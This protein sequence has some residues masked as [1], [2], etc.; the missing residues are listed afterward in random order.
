[1]HRHNYKLILL[2]LII[3]ISTALANEGLTISFLDVGQGDSELLQFN[4]KSM[5]IDGSTQD[6]GSRVECYLKERGVSSLDL[7]VATHPHEDH[8]GGLLTVLNDFPVRQILDSGEVHTSPTFESYL[9]L[10]DR[11]NIS[12]EVA[13]R[14][15]TINLDPDLE[16]E[17]LS[18]SATHFPDDLN[19]NSVVLKVNYENVSFLF[20]GDAGTEAENS[21]LSSGYDL[22]ADVL[23]VGHHGSSSASSTA[24]LNA[25]TPFASVI[26]VG[27]GNDYGHPTQRTLNALKRTGS[28]IYRTDLDGNIVVT[29][30]G[31]S[32][33]VTTGR[34]SCSSTAP[35]STSSAIA[36]TSTQP[37][38]ATAAVQVTSSSVPFVGSSKGK[39]YHYL[40]CSGA[41]SIKSGNLVT[42]ASSADARAAGYTPC[43]M[44]NPP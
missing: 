22:D 32:I 36:P 25:V 42:F 15:Q 39:K 35:S 11:K 34:S 30:D 26:E 4:G 9:N 31:E 10:I 2:A 37:A 5:L 17:V 16:I 13:E 23:K 1:M 18:P 20:A 38:T 44:C 33:T 43:S 41:K 19:Q 28:A 27:A 8:I 24:F 14:G 29:T 40:T 21:L 12:F 3:A 6:M 7:V